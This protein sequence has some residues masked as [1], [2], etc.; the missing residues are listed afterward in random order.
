MYP[1]QD[2]W[3]SIETVDETGQR[4]TVFHGRHDV[5]SKEARE[6]WYGD[7]IQAVREHDS[8]K[9]TYKL[10]P[11]HLGRVVVSLPEKEDCAT[12]CNA[13]CRH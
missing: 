13:G 8:S 2:G 1:N 6:K 7:L 10:V 4:R 9:A 11:M 5:H 12:P 3:L